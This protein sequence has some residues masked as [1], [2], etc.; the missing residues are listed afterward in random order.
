M[1]CRCVFIST[2][3]QS[4]WR[5]RLRLPGE[6]STRSRRR[7]RV[8]RLRQCGADHLEERR[9]GKFCWV[10]NFYVSLQTFA[11]ESCALF[12]THA[13]FRASKRTRY[14]IGSSPTVSLN[15][16]AKVDRD[17]QALR[18]RL[19]GPAMRRIAMH[20][21]DRS[22][23]LLVGEREQPAHARPGAL[24]QVQPQGQDQ[25]RVRPHCKIAKISAILRAKTAKVPLCS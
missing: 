11:S 22:A 6:L 13:A 1:A 17:M 9:I 12:A 23:H 25:Q 5:Q 24:R 16:C 7:H 2:L 15:L 20:G 18:Q 4:I 14:S 19:Q 10:T 21:I 3:L 8:A